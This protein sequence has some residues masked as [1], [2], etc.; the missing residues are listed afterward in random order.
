MWEV[1]PM[2]IVW[3]L[4][5]ADEKTVPD[6]VADFLNGKRKRWVVNHVYGLR[7]PSS[8]DQD[9][10]FA[11]FRKALRDLINPWIDSGRTV[12]EEKQ[13][14]TPSE[15]KRTFAINETLRSFWD[16]NPLRVEVD[17]DG[18][19]MVARVDPRRPVVMTQQ[20]ALGRAADYGVAWFARLLLESES[21]ER[22]FRCDGDGCGTYFT[23]I[24]T[25]KKG[26]P[27]KR[28]VF[29]EGCKN[30]GGAR[31]TGAHREGQ[32]GQ[33]LKV[34]AEWWPQWTPTTR[35][36][37]SR[38]DWIVGKMN[39]HCRA[40]GMKLITKKWVTQNQAAIEEQISRRE[41]AKG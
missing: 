13:S 39:E 29:C 34:A 14:E 18:G 16:R 19:P 32:K 1:N 24:P 33:M 17:I 35:R 25:P 20:D 7:R 27:I 15:R 36:N 5:G 41:H 4:S 21:P 37:R 26:V 28:G 9:A 6:Y 40:K 11:T 10:M 38:A 23:R 8:E 22:L 2:K 30:K 3:D 31:R 12:Y